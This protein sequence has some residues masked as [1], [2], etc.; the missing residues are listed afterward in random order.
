MNS[1]KPPKWL[2]WAGIGMLLIAFWMWGPGSQPPGYIPVANY[3]HS[4][5]IDFSEALKRVKNDPT[6][7]EKLVFVKGLRQFPDKV[8]V[9][10]AGEKANFVADIPGEFDYNIIAAEADRQNV[11]KQSLPMS[12]KDAQQE[13]TM[14]PSEDGG[15]NPWSR[16]I[17]TVL[18]VAMI[19]LPI[20]GIIWLMRSMQNMQ[21]GGGAA[22]AFAKSKHRKF[23]PDKGPKVTFAD[24]AGVDE[25]KE[26]LEMVVEFLKD[27]SEL[28]GLGGKLAKGVLLIGKPGTGKTL[29]AKAVAGEANVP[30][31]YVNAPEFVEMFVGVG[32]A[33]VRDLFAEI[34]KNLPCILAIDE[35]DAVGQHR[36]TGIGGGNDE[37]QQ[38]I[39]QLMTEIDG[40]DSTEGLVA[41]AM[42]NR[43]D[44]L[45]PAIVRGGRFGTKVVV[46]APDKQGR[47]DII[48][49]HARGV[50]LDPNLDLWELSGAMSG[51]VGADIADVIKVHGPLA[52]IKR[53]RKLFGKSKKA[54]MITRDDL[55]KGISQIHMGGGATEGRSKRLSAEVK[56]LLAYHEL[57]HALVG[58]FLFRMNQGWESLWHD[59]VR[60]ITIIGAGG[61]GGYTSFHGDED[62]FCQTYEQLLGMITSLLAAT[63]AE[64]MFLNT[65]STGAQNDIERAYEIAKQM[66]TQLG[67]SK[68][69]PISAGK[70]GGNPY[71][72]M[73]M[74]QSGGYGLGPES[75][76]QIDHEIFLILAD[77]MM[78]ADRILKPLSDLMHK[79]APV[80]TEDETMLREK[81]SAMWDQHF[82]SG[83][84]GVSMDVIPEAELVKALPGLGLRVPQRMLE[85]AA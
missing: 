62:P 44:V 77:C 80:L 34:R 76:N 40:F 14:G 13:Y 58:E 38:T 72:G 23:E 82:A 10:G 21:N 1:F 68:L 31:F 37:R 22:G 48:K 55:D 75:S 61:A 26:Q 2:L 49:V 53:S 33:R 56:R 29:L 17:S 81:F 15:H 84:P 67:M 36:G 54:E 52:A 25:A 39:L 24:V 35:L 20:I 83:L 4:E 50:K 11:A 3:A 79:L 6:S 30:F 9:D 51:L 41:F 66:V 27:P 74:A 71:L 12:G 5:R 70:T 46:G 63:R 16:V 8:I 60:K 59:Q 32:A 7:I 73:T 64:Q 18:M 69:G 57:G 43:P 28:T 65:R 85:Q 78:R 47:F 42:T 19:A 45:D